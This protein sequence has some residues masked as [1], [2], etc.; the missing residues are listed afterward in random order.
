M[1]SIPSGVPGERLTAGIDGGASIVRLAQECPVCTRKR[2]LFDVAATSEFSHKE[3]F[4]VFLLTAVYT[5][6]TAFVLT[7]SHAYVYMGNAMKHSLMGQ[8]RH[9]KEPPEL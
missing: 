2:T 7:T 8:V 5:N 1:R 3:T 9:V 6:L 4:N